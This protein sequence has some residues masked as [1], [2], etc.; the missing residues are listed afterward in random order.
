MIKKDKLRLD[1][2][3]VKALI[4]QGE[5]D[6]AQFECTRVV[7]EN[8]AAVQPLCLMSYI[9]YLQ[10]R[11][12]D[13][14][15]YSLRAKDAISLSSDWKDVLSA[16]N[17]LLMVGEERDSILVMNNIT[18]LQD[19]ESEYIEFIAKH[20]G[21][22]DLLERAVSVFSAA[23]PEKMSYHSWQMFGVAQ[24]YLGNEIE[25]EHCFNRAI[26]RNPQDC[27][28]YNQLSALRK[29]SGREDRIHALHELSK[30]SELDKINQSYLNFSLFN[31]LDALKDY[32]NAFNHLEKANK[33]RRSMVSYDARI[34]R[35]HYEAIISQFRNA[36]IDDN[37]FQDVR[38]ETPI[39]IVGMP[40]T[41]TTLLE[42]ITSRY[43]NVYSCGELNTLRLQIQESS[44][45]ML[46]QPS[47]IGLIDNLASL[48]Y[49][50]IGNEYMRKVIWRIGNAKY[51]TDKHPSNNV[52]VGIIAKSMPNAKIIHITKNPM[53][54]CFSNF[55]QLFS[56]ESYTYSYSQ[57]D[58]V[59]YYKNYKFLM[60]FWE[61]K[62]ADR[63][64]TVKYED[65]VLSTDAQAENIRQFCGL[66]DHLNSS[67]RFV[68][69]T[70]S[71]SQV[72]KPIH[73]GNI[74][75]WAKY[76]EFLQPMREGLDHEYVSY[77]KKISGIEVL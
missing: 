38:R 31:E 74:N 52:L 71:A 1:V 46:R 24:L 40:R 32:R 36:Q 75:A 22:L 39:F 54:A 5:L 18:N 73:T 69:N 56:I 60:D 20:Y 50:R 62:F 58:L 59:N 30:S 13:A 57:N 12:F 6:I 10:K 4:S 47:D 19:L 21:K 68:T 65:L 14:R 29:T 3:Y 15:R 67:D 42:K 51:F 33:I 11:F 72:R 76:A 34:E 61:S 44:G 70:L 2:D 16:S 77:M 28:S 63:I 41:G 17:A 7:A 25:A 53:D 9:L 55:K 45:V 8:P 48:D 43:A 27:I 26:S 23:D 64:L 37:S 49:E 66:S 35:E